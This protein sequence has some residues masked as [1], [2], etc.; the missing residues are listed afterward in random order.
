MATLPS[1]R[2]NEAPPFT[3]CGLDCFGPFIVKDGRKESKRYGLIVTCMASRAV[4]IE[5]LE[6]MTTDSFI[7]AVRTVVAIRGPIQTIQ[8][9][10]GTNFIG[11]ASLLQS[12][13]T[14]SNLKSMNITMN[15][16]PPHSS[17]FGG[18]WE[19]QIRTIRSVLQGLGTRHGGR[20]ST[21]LLRTL[22]YEVMAIINCR[23]LT[24]TTDDMLQITPN[25]LL[26]MKSDVVLPPPSTFEEADIYARK[27]WRVVQQLA[28]EFWT[29]WRKQY[30][31]FLQSRQKWVN[32]VPEIRVG[33][34]VLLC[35]DNAVRNQWPLARVV[36]C[37][38][39]HDSVV[40]SV[41]V[42]VGSKTYPKD[43]NKRVYLTRPI[44]KLVVLVRS[45]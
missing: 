39:S 37:N 1:V 14:D 36:E 15:F 4:H 6:D 9:D 7:N 20:L 25:I 43:S 5:L 3:H 10:Q 26:T 34:I 22:F 13:G 21:S 41:K 16:N 29:R 40:R 33:D 17:N 38:L 31:L 28:N 18:V 8:S 35:D 30:L 42:L 2:V 19:R 44:S 11:A 12:D 23:P 24:S 45:N 27:R 32:K